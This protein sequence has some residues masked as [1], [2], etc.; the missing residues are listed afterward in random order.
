M[1]CILKGKITPLNASIKGALSGGSQLSAH[2][3]LGAEPHRFE[4]SYDYTP[5]EEAQTISIEGMLAT[6]DIVIQPIPT[7]YGLLTW[8]GNTLT[9][10]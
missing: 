10:S 3:T 9:V 6:E 2:I 1:S 8:N 7:N 5:T 4:G